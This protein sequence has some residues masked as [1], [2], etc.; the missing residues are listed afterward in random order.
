LRKGII[1]YYKIN[2]IMASKKHVDIHHVEIAKK[3]GKKK[4]QSIEVCTPKKT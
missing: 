2:G 3:I 1:S 4:K